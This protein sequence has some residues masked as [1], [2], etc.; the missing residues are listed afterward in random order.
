MLH[1]KMIVR[2]FKSII[3]KS[4][5]E[6]AS[7]LDYFFVNYCLKRLKKN[8]L[9]ISFIFLN[10]FAH[11]QHHYMLSS[12]YVDGSNPDWYVKDNIDPLF[13]SL[14]IYD[15][16]FVKIFDKY[17]LDSDI[18][19]I[20]GL[21]QS[22]Y[23]KPVIYW[24]FNNHHLI[25]N[26]FLNFKFIIN[27]RMTRDFEV[28]VEDKVNIDKALDFFNNAKIKDDHEL[29]NAFGHIDK[30][31]DNTIFV[32]FIY[33]M[34]KKNISLVYNDI[35]YN[36]NNEISF[37]AIKN[38]EHNEKGWAFSNFNVRNSENKIKIWDL[39]SLILQN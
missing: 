8:S 26:K 2:S 23:K 21:T 1:F 22:P 38:G 25:L 12:E 10:G 11:V 17:Q 29:S 13:N 15:E 16:L 7:L 35:E 27:P 32:S 5:S 3:S 9:D 37:V 36:L 30:Q 24:R 34:N 33:E 6:L 20:T 39:S 4:R 31:H 14:K 19:I 28:I 18:W